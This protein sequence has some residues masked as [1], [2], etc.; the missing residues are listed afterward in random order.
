MSATPPAGRGAAGRGSA[1]FAEL[2]LL[3]KLLD[4][5]PERAQDRPVA[6]T[7]S[8]ERLHR[9]VRRDV[10]ALLNARRPWRSPPR[11][12]PGLRLSPLG[13][14]LADF[15][16]GAFQG[17]AQREA[18]RAEIEETIRRFE[19]R[20]AGVQVSLAEDGGPLRATLRMRIEG[21]LRVQPAPEPVAFDTAVDVTTADVT[22]QPTRVP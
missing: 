2:P 16:A 19:P 8:V 5:E 21:L 4:A 20:L 7:E 9:A 18:L 22:V 6:A 1:G 15:T 12:M 11:T 17:R 3:D 10:E 13:Y 14:G